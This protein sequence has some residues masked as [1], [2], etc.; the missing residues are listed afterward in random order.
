MI[1]RNNKNFVTLFKRVSFFLGI[2]VVFLGSSVILGY[3]LDNQFMKS[4]FSGLV[5]MNPL[6]AI[7][8]I[9][10]GISLMCC[11][12]EKGKKVIFYVGL[13]CALLV[14]F[15]G[16]LKFSGVLLNK[17]IHLDN[18][19]FSQQLNAEALVTGQTNRMA[20]NTALSF[21]IAGISLI[22]LYKKNDKKYAQLFSVISF[23]IGF[24]AFLGYLYG[25]KNFIGIV[26]YIPMALNTAISFM[27]LSVGMLFSFPDQ[28]LMIFL[29]T[30]TTAG[31]V[32][33]KLIPPAFFFPS[34]FGYLDIL[35]RR[36]GI[37]PH[38]FSMSL[39]IVGIIM[40]L[41]PFIWW[42]GS[43]LYELEKMRQLADEKLI[44]EKKKNE[45]LLASIGD[46]VV[47]IDREWNVTLFN[48]AA[49][50]LTGWQE[51]EV[52]GQPLRKFIKFMH[53]KDRSENISFIEDAM[54]FG[55]VIFMKNPSFFVDK[56]GN[57]IPVGDSA[58]PVFDDAGNVTGAII[59]FRNSSEEKESRTLKSDFAYASHQLNTPV[60]KALWSID[61]AIEEKDMVKIKDKLNIAHQSIKSTQKLVSQLYTVSIIDQK[62]ILPSYKNVNLAN[63]FETAVSSLKE[64]ADKSNII[65]K[66]EGI[67][68]LAEIK[69]DPKLLEQVFIELIENAINYNKPEGEIDIRVSIDENKKNIILSFKDNGIGIPPEQQSII[70]TKFFRGNNFDTTEIVG[71]GLGLF[72]CHEYV[73]ILGGKIWFDSEKG[74][75][76]FFVSLPLN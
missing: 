24:L 37:F 53:E 33:R 18:Y 70:F 22:L 68:Y 44:Q 52:I 39:S 34:L 56:A 45:I 49:T 55:K 48:N 26:N 25:V 30:E 60:T 10:S 3:F 27:L 5:S 28:G 47:A 40:V 59:V 35:L 50:L 61:Q 29:S 23:F 76:I 11:T 57:D 74:K 62:N 17:D 66:T 1:E 75:T 72:I 8:F 65:I 32:T 54:L 67:S 7:A 21:L 9:L 15:I 20:P 58:A 73:N 71:A 51:Q 12:N 42:I 69:T 63:L 31:I 19:F 14:F 36:R 2:V 16:L 46:G 4:V 43:V 41:F 13:T 38:E 6:T 64:K